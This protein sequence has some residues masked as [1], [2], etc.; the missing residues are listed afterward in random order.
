M[1]EK[2]AMQ[3][4]R[5]SPV[6]E[7][8]VLNKLKR[9]HT[10]SPEPLSPASTHVKK[11]ARGDGDGTRQVLLGKARLPQ[12]VNHA[13]GGLAS[14]EST[15]STV[16]I[17]SS[18]Q[19]R[20]PATVGSAAADS[21]AP[22]ANLS[23]NQPVDVT[24]PT[25][26][27]PE[28]QADARKDS[29]AST[30]L[31]STSVEQQQR[32]Q[33]MK[34]DSE[35]TRQTLDTT[36]LHGNPDTAALS[37][38]E[39]TPLQ[40][41]IENVLN[42][43]ILMK[44][45]E[46]RLIDQEL[47][48][49]QIAL[50]QLRRCELRPYP[51][52]KGPSSAI[53]AGTG[54]SIEPRPGFT[55]PSNPTPYGVTDG[56]Y[57]RHYRQWLIPDPQFDSVSHSSQLLQETSAQARSTRTGASARKSTSKSYA[58][59][60][61]TSEH[62][63]SIPNY[64]AHIGKDKS[65]P[66]V[67]RRPTDGQMVK[68]ICNNCQRGNFSSVQG[69]LNHCRIAHKVDYKSHDAAALDCGRPLEKHEVSSLPPEAHKTTGPK[70][71]MRLTSSTSTKNSV[72][73]LNQKAEQA[74]GLVVA[75][76]VVDA[77]RPAAVR[78]VRPLAAAAPPN[79]E[80]FHAPPLVKSAETPY[81]SA[82]FAKRGLGGDLQLATAQAKQKVDLTQEESEEI[83]ADA[84]D[85]NS[86]TQPGGSRSAPT[87]GRAGMLSAPASI[88][89]PPSRKTHRQPARPR[90]SPLAPSSN[91]H[92]TRQ[93]HHEIPE[94]PQ[95][96]DSNLSPHTADSNPGLVSDVDDDDEVASEEEAPTV[97]M[98]EDSGSPHP[99]GISRTC[100]DEMDIDVEIQDHHPEDHG[101]L[102]RSRSVMAAAD[103]RRSA[104]SPS[105]RLMPGK[106]QHRR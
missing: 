3:K 102:V 72:N 90:P 106:D 64:P 95:E 58:T 6:V 9:K 97:G 39:L 98:A 12:T 46:Q 75:T 82:Q 34:L 31:S 77:T 32:S 78:P 88:E 21:K 87:N 68:L 59:P 30:P 105:R 29:H 93:D 15:A 52:V 11:K 91:M 101:V 43:Q 22:E 56:P 44:H 19:G 86:P 25:L 89:R 70:P 63:Q 2:L 81:L 84:L 23:N 24:L 92:S 33:H 65:S 7:I 35:M 61:R 1:S 48:K 38:S 57:A 13:P 17:R 73:P 62:L 55:R 83:A 85:E 28:K 60:A 42:L 27:V 37:G 20:P 40:R 16:N 103:V 14:V 79:A 74:R 4:M 10:G 104:G 50:E 36:T 26:H 99:L 47:A 94:S 8:P 5:T 69:F 66:L 54:S 76:P 67:L 100:G 18:D 41:S 71:V 96:H 53:S 80:A 45:R 51:G 49:C